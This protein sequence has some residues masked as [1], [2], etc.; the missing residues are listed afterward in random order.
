VHAEESAAQLQQDREMLAAAA[1]GDERAWRQVVHRFKRLVYS[2]PRGYRFSEEACDDIFQTV[3]T[4]LVRELPRI[5]D[6][7][8][9]PKWLITTTHRACWKA[10]RTAQ[11]TLSPAAPELLSAE[12][13]PDKVE[14]LER[15]QTLET[16]L[17]ALGGRCEALLRLLYL[18]QADVSYEEISSQ[19]G[20]A[21]GSIGPTRTRCLAKLAELLE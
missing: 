17:A 2:I 3:F 10:A 11:T 21:V 9:V 1:R 4:A 13:E 6:V 15:L 8:A 18:A 12:L 5:Q 14:R 19:L 20:M 7:Q 16:A